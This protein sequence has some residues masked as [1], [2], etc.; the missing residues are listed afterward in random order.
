MPKKKEETMKRNKR[1]Y[2][3]THPQQMVDLA[4]DSLKK[5][6]VSSYEAEKIFGI[7]RRTLLDKLHK[8]HPNNPGCPT[9][10]CDQEESNIIKV[11]LAAA[12]YGSPLTLLDLRIV[13]QR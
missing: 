3:L 6:E 5:K 1:N 8:K 2:T 9:R 4:L 13:V 12:E 11:L 7:P 10:L